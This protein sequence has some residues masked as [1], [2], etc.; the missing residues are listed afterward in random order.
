VALMGVRTFTLH[1]INR[2]KAFTNLRYTVHRCPCKYE[3]KTAHLFW[4][5]TT[6]CTR[7]LWGRI[8]RDRIFLATNSC[9]LSSYIKTCLCFYIWLHT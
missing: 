6:H 4:Y 7:S 2:C 5:S 9:N 1:R 3:H 8:Q